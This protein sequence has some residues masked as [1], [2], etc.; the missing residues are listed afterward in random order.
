MSELPDDRVRVDFDVEDGVATLFFVT[1]LGPGCEQRLAGALLRLA[2]DR[3][4]E[5]DDALREIGEHGRAVED[6]G[7]E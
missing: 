4:P 5:L 6:G 7:K 1:R 2:S 3:W